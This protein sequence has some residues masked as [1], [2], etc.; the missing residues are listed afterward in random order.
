VDPEA[1]V[2]DFMTALRKGRAH[3]QPF[4]DGQTRYRAHGR[5]WEG[6]AALVALLAVAARGPLTATEM[7]LRRNLVIV[8]W[9]AGAEA[10]TWIVTVGRDGTI[11]DV[12]QP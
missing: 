3:A 9:Q 7:L 8:G 5:S 1:R 11:Q 10:G 4:T 2:R 12:L 6:D